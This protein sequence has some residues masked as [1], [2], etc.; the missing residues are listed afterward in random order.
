M[1][2]AARGARLGDEARG[3]VLFTDE[4]RMDDLDRDGA[5]E[6]RLLGAIHAAHAAD[7]D[8]IEDDVAARER[9]TD[10]RIVRML[11]HLRDGEAARRTEL[12]RL[13]ARVLALGTRPH[14]GEWPGYHAEN[15]E[16]TIATE[17]LVTPGKSA[18][19]R[20]PAWSVGSRCA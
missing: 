4:V 18:L 19:W 13:L 1:V 2:E 3:G 5:T 8:E 7:A 20:V 11:R 9:A 10:E 17:P 16:R 6:V 15:A 14:H 12:V